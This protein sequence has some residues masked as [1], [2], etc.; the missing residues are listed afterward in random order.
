VQLCVSGKFSSV[1]LNCQLLDSH[2]YIS[3][4][5]PGSY[6]SG[7]VASQWQR[8]AGTQGRGQPLTVLGE[9]PGAWS[10]NGSAG[11]A[12]RGVVS[13]WQR[14]ESN[15]GRGYGS[16]V[17]LSE[18]LGAVSGFSSSSSSYYCYYNNY[19]CYC[20]YNLWDM[21]SLG[22]AKASFVSYVTPEVK[23]CAEQTSGLSVTLLTLKC[24]YYYD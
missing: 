6:G 8:W 9:H 16:S 3:S 11:R 10:A 13:Q 19:C 2:F 20:Y 14:W 17:R 21:S 23:V 4:D 18:S 24:Y 12:P 7:G 15:R 22:A 5:K 1:E